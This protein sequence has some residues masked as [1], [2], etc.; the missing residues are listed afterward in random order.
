[1]VKCKEYKLAY[2]ISIYIHTSFILG[3][4]Q[5]SFYI[6]ENYCSNMLNMFHKSDVNMRYVTFIC[7]SLIFLR[8]P[9]S[10]TGVFPVDLFIWRGPILGR[11]RPYFPVSPSI[12]LEKKRNKASTHFIGNHLRRNTERPN[13]ERPSISRGNT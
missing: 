2:V 3:P 1:M 6:F 10:S 13:V 4:M 11:W 5:C 7:P 12:N 9:I 8:A